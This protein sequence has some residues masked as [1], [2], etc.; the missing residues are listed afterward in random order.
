MPDEIK[1]P[2]SREAL[3]EAFELSGQILNDLE[4][5][6]I[7][8]TSIALKTGRLARL[9][10]DFAVHSIMEYESGGYPAEPDGI[11][12]D[13]FELG[14]R[15][16][17]VATVKDPK[18]GEVT[19]QMSSTASIAELESQMA[20]TNAALAAAIDSDA[21][22]PPGPFAIQGNTFERNAIRQLHYSAANQIAKSRAFIYNYVSRVYYEL[23]LSDIADD[24]FT[25]IRDR[26]D[27]T[28]GTVIPGAV[29]KMTAVYDNL[30]SDNPEDWSNAVHGCRRLLQDLADTVFPA[31][32]DEDAT[33]SPASRKPTV[34]LG[35]EHYINRLIAFAQERSTSGRFTDIVGSQLG[36]LGD[37]LDAVFRAAQKGSHSDIVSRVEADRYVVYT[38]LLVGDLLSLLTS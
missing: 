29:R 11:P 33:G 17:R 34:K 6:T 38:Y 19:E 9:L 4:T 27:Q 7:S 10:N 24:V 14:R 22:A 18:T 12:P 28:I 8:L 2:P 3:R 21:P 25:R 26:V 37:R 16:G 30:R 32:T 20:L 13:A 5:S 31:R 36:F 35:Q 1:I 23:K 15:T